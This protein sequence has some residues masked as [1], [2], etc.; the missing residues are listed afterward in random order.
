MDK[1]TTI[2]IILVLFIS[3][4]SFSFGTLIG[5]KVSEHDHARMQALEKAHEEIK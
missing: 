4:L 1:D 5:K 2:K 3:L